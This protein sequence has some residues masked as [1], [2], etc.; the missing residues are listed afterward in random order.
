[1]NKMVLMT[2]ATVFC[3]IVLTTQAVVFCNFEQPDYIAQFDTVGQ[4]GWIAIDEQ[5]PLVG[6]PA[7]KI[8]PDPGPWGS[9]YDENYV[10]EGSQSAFIGNWGSNLA[11]PFVGTEPLGDLAV[12][13]VLAWPEND[14]TNLRIAIFPD[15]DVVVSDVNSY[16]STLAFGFASVPGDANIPVHGGKIGVFTHSAGKL[17]FQPSN[18]ISKG[19]HTYL[20]EA[21]LDFTGQRYHLYA[22]D[23]MASGSKIKLGTYNASLPTPAVMLAGGGIVVSSYGGALVFDDI[24]IAKISTCEQLRSY[25]F[26]QAADLYPDCKIDLKDVGEFAVQWLECVDPQDVTCLKPWQE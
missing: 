22:T 10:L 11:R 3:M 2:A 15:L 23:I 7:S 6:D 4:D 9:G 18:I 24:R 26:I 16:P 19:R 5:D 13:S 8:M 21:V 17:V 20:L 1:M 14:M 12:V 25:G